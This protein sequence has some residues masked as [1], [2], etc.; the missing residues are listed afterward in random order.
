MGIKYLFFI[1]FTAASTCYAASI[2]FK[3]SIGGNSP[4]HGY[5]ARQTY[6]NGY[7]AVGTTSSFTNGNSDIYVVRTAARP[8]G[9]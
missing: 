8:L 2:Q 5:C 1:V 3:H 4:D 7:I 6:D 9:K